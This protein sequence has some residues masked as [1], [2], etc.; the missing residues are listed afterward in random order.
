MTLSGMRNLLCAGLVLLIASAVGAHADDGISQ[1]AR[2]LIQRGDMAFS[3]VEELRARAQALTARIESFDAAAA[4]RG[5][6][7][8]LTA[9]DGKGAGTGPTTRSAP[10]REPA[11]DPSADLEGLETDLDRTRVKLR[12]FEDLARD[13]WERALAIDADAQDAILQ[14]LRGSGLKS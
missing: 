2:S 3:R 6:E 7:E 10:G 13:L 4:A 14:R 8:D 11:P 9:K 5:A 1:E 12:W